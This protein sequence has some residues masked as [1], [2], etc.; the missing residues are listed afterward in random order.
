MNKCIENAT[1]YTFGDQGLGKSTAPQLLYNALTLYTK[2]RSMGGLKLLDEQFTKVAEKID[3]DEK[4]QQE[5]KKNSP[6]AFA[7]RSA[8]VAAE[9]ES[10]F[11]EMDPEELQGSYFGNESE[12]DTNEGEEKV[13]SVTARLLP[14]FQLT[15]CMFSLNSIDSCQDQT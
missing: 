9:V 13:S 15:V 5:A 12:E 6:M 10:R 11:N 3:A 1:K 8:R 14:L 4:W 7:D 2:I